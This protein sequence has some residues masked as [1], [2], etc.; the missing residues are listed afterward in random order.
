ME[1]VRTTEH[2]GNSCWKT[3]SGRIRHF[4]PGKKR[5]WHRTKCKSDCC[6]T[7]N[8]LERKRLKVRLREDGW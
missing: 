6:V 4:H 7:P 5:R 8:R 3:K 2:C 1:Y